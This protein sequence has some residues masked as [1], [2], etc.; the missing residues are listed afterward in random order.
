MS[1]RILVVGATSAIAQEAIKLW[2]NQGCKL[3]LWGRDA[4][5]LKAIAADAK[6]RGSD[7]KTS[8]YTTDMEGKVISRMVKKA[9]ETW[10]GLDGVLLAHGWLPVQDDVQDDPDAVTEV[11]DVN[12]LSV[13][14]LLAVLAPHFEEQ[15]YG[16]LAAIS[17]VAGDRG[18]A[19]MYVYGGAKALVQ[20]WLEGLRQ[21]LTPVGVRV[22]D[23]RPGPVDTPMTKGLSMPLMADPKDIGAGVVKACANANG[24]V[25]LPW[26][27][28]TI[29][30]ILKHVPTILWVRMK[31]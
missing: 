6:V 30:L 26:V 22:I 10:D 27:W 15:R 23:I 28:R 1:E 2:A 31:I 17:S 13:I 16:W 3:Q 25:Y 7:V 12:G 24:A 11:T 20:H 18:R 8:V 19:K 29:M 9:M 21:R 5:K 14:Q 4:A